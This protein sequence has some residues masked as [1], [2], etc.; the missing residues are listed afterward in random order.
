MTLPFDPAAP[1]DSAEPWSLPPGG[2][3]T[4]L[5]RRLRA[6]DADILG[7][8]TARSGSFASIDVTGAITLASGGIV[9]TAA[10][11]QRLELT[12]SDND[13]LSMYTG[14]SFEDGP[15]GL[16]AAV[17]GAGSTRTLQ[18]ALHAPVTT[19]DSGGVTLTATSESADDSTTPPRVI[20][21][22]TGGSSLVPELKMQNSFIVLLEDGSVTVPAVG[23]NNSVNMGLYRISANVMGVTIDGVEAARFNSF[24]HLLMATGNNIYTDPG[25]VGDPGYSVNGDDDTG[26]FFPAADTMAW[27]TGG[28]EGLRIRSDQNV[29]VGDAGF[30]SHRFSVTSVAG[31]I[32][33]RFYRPTAT[34][35]SQVVNIASDVGGT[36]TLTLRIDADGDAFNIN[37]TYG[38]ISDRRLKVKSSIKDARPYLDDLCK[39]KVRHYRLKRTKQ[40]N[41]GFVADEVASVFPGLVRRDE[42]GYDVVKTSVLIPMLVQAIQ[43]LRAL[44]DNP[45]EVRT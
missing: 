29:G 15:G 42:N 13:T 12:S 14:D 38:T 16:I 1:F 39:L 10:S 22:Y 40:T 35:S 7:H 24:G 44:I 37:G 27:A 34:A 26:G 3:L 28:V 19:G 25:A 31:S 18:S 20:V 43:E 5:T 36:G 11:G 9:R 8:I 6:I 23:F 2:N 45:E 33:V 41:L 4:D 32:P 21:G 30:S 17:S